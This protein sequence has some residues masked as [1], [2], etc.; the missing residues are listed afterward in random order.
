MFF[1]GGKKFNLCPG[2]S[3]FLKDCL[4]RSVRLLASVGNF[5]S[6]HLCLYEVAAGYMILN[7]L[8]CASS[9]RSDREAGRDVLQTG[10]AYSQTGRMSVVYTL[11]RNSH[12]VDTLAC[13]T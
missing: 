7:E 1:L 9:S 5:E 12:Q 2:F 4:H 3:I 11:R 6:A 8:F 13:F 10:A